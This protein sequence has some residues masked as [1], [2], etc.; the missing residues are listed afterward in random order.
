MHASPAAGT[1]GPLHL[2]DLTHGQRRLTLWRESDPAG[3]VYI[4]FSLAVPVV[5]QPPGEAP[6]TEWVIVADAADPEPLLFYPH[7]DSHEGAIVFDNGSFK[8]LGIEVDAIADYL[9][10][11]T[12]G[13]GN[14]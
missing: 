12:D 11:T 10:H 2:Y 8:L 6:Q 5:I 4:H 1:A 9:G 13:E 3:T 14:A 7:G